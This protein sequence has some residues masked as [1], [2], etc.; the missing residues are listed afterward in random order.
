MD[1]LQDAEMVWSMLNSDDLRLKN[2]QSLFSQSLVI[3]ES[4]L[5]NRSSSID[6][7]ERYLSRQTRIQTWSLQDQFHWK[8]F[9]CK[10]LLLVNRQP[11][12]CQLF[13]E[14]NLSLEMC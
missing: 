10:A 7:R 4:A 5:I 9:M 12:G 3:L 11:E 14:V 1:V 6:W 13:R 8:S 2:V